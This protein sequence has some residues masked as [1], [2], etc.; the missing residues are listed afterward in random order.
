MLRD[1][2]ITESERNDLSLDEFDP[3]NYIEDFATDAIIEKVF[4]IFSVL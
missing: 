4:N 3:I 2:R 1:G